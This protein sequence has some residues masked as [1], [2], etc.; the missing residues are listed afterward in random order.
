MWSAIVR[1]L[2]AVSP[3][4]LKVFDVQPIIGRDFASGDAKKGAAPTLLV[5]YGYW[6]QYLGAPRDLSQSHLKI[7]DAI[8]A[9]IGVMP[10]RFPGLR[11]PWNDWNHVA[12]C[13]GRWA[14]VVA[15]VVL[16]D[17]P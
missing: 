11:P 16:E 15:E 4:F 12:Q 3:D 6:K 1:S 14:T 8:F 9:V 13:G 10:D 7:G 5:S 17:T 2:A